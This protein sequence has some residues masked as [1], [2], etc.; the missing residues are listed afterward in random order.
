MPF[1]KT[2]IDKIAETQTNKLVVI[3]ENNFVID[4]PKYPIKEPNNGENKIMYS[5]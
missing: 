3:S 1:Q 5:I 2:T 4:L